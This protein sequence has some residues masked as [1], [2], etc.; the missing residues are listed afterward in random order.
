MTDAQIYAFMRSLVPALNA[1]PDATLQ[2]WVDLAR[3]YVCQDKFGNDAG[4][5]VGLYALHLMMADG[6]MKPESEGIKSYSRRVASHSL[7]GEFSIT[8]DSING[9]DSSSLSSTPWG[10]MYKAILRKK[11]GGFG[12][13]T[14]GGRGCGC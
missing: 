6:A 7:N 14:S 8:Y 2:V 11:G 12:L 1:V 10:N 9:A 3:L 13:I 5:A 4:R